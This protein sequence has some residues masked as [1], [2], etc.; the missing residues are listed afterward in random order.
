M[1]SLDQTSPSSRCIKWGVFKKRPLNCIFPNP[2]SHLIL[3]VGDERGSEFRPVPGVAPP[4]AY[5]V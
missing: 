2:Q 1:M 4:D 5:Y 3:P